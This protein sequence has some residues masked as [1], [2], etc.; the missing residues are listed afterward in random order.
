[1]QLADAKGVL[2]DVEGSCFQLQT[3]ISNVSSAN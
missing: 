2:S 1:M 3:Q